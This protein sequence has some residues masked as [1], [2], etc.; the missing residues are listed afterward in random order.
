[1]KIIE[2]RER[3]IEIRALERVA[4][5]DMINAGAVFADDIHAVALAVSRRSERL[6]ERGG[7]RINPV[8]GEM[9]IVSAPGDRKAPVKARKKKQTGSAV[10]R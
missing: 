9:R 7:T 2:L 6:T 8:I 5:S 4:L 10:L 1:M 3:V